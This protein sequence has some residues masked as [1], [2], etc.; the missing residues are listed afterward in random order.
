MT[1]HALFDWDGV[2]NVYNATTRDIREMNLRTFSV[3]SSPFVYKMKCHKWLTNEFLSRNHPG[4][5][6]AW[7]TT[8]WDRVNDEL[9]NRIGLGP[10]PSVVLDYYLVDPHASKIPGILNYVGNDPFVWFDDDPAPGDME[11]L[12]S[13]PNKNLFI[14]IDPYVGITREHLDKAHAWAARNQ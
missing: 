11:T 6:P 4:L 5:K 1:V 9:G 7:C 10:W 13:L 3:H 12:A 8:W 2:L 14:R